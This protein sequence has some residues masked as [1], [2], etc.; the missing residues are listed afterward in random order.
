MRLRTL[1]M[2]TL[3]MCTLKIHALKNALAQNACAL[4]AGV[5]K[6][7]KHYFNGSFANAG[8]LCRVQQ[9]HCTPRLALP[10]TY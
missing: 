6:A 1:K 7:F 10:F 5:L 3:K 2:R 8:Q 4:K 9:F